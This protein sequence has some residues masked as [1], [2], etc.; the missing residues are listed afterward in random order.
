MLV[1][2]QADLVDLGSRVGAWRRLENGT[3]DLVLVGVPRVVTGPLLPIGLEEGS[4]EIA[5]IPPTSGG[6]GSRE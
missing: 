6:G 2:G 1:V 5:G 4:P 3:L